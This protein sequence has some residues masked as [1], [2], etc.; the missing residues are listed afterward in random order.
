MS[1]YTPIWIGLIIFF[2]GYTGWQMTL[3]LTKNR[4]AEIDPLN[5]PEALLP[6]GTAEIV[7]PAQR[8]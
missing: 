7:R 8:S 5:P 1:E 3:W 6:S 2:G 4:P